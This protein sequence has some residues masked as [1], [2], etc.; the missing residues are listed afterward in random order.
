M[1]S[2]SQVFY[3]VKLLTEAEILIKEYDYLSN[4]EVLFS[5]EVEKNTKLLTVL[6]EAESFCRSLLNVKQ[7]SVITV[8]Q[9][10][11]SKCLEC[12]I[13]DK[14]SLKI[15]LSES[16]NRPSCEI[17]L[18]RGDKELSLRDEE[19]GGGVVDIVSFGLRLAVWLV[20]G[21]PGNV[22][23]LDEPLK[24]LQSMPKEEQENL[25]TFIRDFSLTFGVQFIIVTHSEPIV[26]AGD[27]IFRVFQD[28]THTSNVVRE[29]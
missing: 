23:V 17:T 21:R 14:Y 20:S 5:Q 11:V 29:L 3:P 28:A 10:I 6:T 16:R 22:F 26:A 2:P 4:K 7:E 24:F 15:E 25:V 19:V 18:C 1:S 9:E 27:R 13:G 8:L 12:I